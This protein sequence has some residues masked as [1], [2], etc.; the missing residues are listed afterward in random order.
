MK[1]L[2]IFVLVSVIFSACSKTEIIF[3]ETKTNEV[4]IPKT[5]IQENAKTEQSNFTFEKIIA[6]QSVP[7]ENQKWIAPNFK[8]LQLGK[9]K[10][11]DVTKLF[12]KAKDEYHPFDEE[13][14]RKTE[15][16]FNYENIADFDGRIEFLFD[17]RSKI[18]NE[19]WLTPNFQNPLTVEKA[20]E[21]YGN[22]Y[23]VRSIKN[24]CSSTKLT[25]VEYPFV[26]VY[27]QKGLFLWI[28][29]ENSVDQIFYTAKCR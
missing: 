15:W 9:A 8:D 5:Q 29:K 12:G 25:K 11:D 3:P 4:S 2:F 24:M 21:I 27:P 14:S 26:I 22:D 6:S 16:M 23:L 13:V 20:I 10:Q 18:L 1:I 28:T 17:I 7:N 19:V